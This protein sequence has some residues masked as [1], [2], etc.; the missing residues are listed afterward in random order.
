MAVSDPRYQIEW[1]EDGP[2]HEVGVEDLVVKND[3]P[4]A[5]IARELMAWLGWL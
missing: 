5:E 4:V 3:R 2:G 1:R